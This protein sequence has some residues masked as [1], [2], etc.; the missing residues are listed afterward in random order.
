MR[1]ISL[2]LLVTAM[3]APTAD[4]QHLIYLEGSTE[5]TLCKVLEETPEY[6]LVRIPRALVVRIESTLP[7]SQPPDDTALVQSAEHLLLPDDSGG[8]QSVRAQIKEELDEELVARRRQESG[9]AV[10]RVLWNGDPLLGCRVRVRR[11]EN[12]GLFGGARPPNEARETLTDEDGFYRFEGLAPGQY[13][14]SWVPPNGDHWVKRLRLEPDFEV[15][16]G[17]SAEVEPLDIH[18]GTLD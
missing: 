3:V 14:L 10:G 18:A 12:G 11:M 15:R 8:T 17:K 9:S 5:G 2:L 1:L 13:K 7:T 6:V 16:L 4:A